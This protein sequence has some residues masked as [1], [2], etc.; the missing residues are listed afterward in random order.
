M[1]ACC[2]L[3]AT[4]GSYLRNPDGS[5]TPIEAP[6]DEA[7]PSE[8][9]ADAMPAVAPTPKPT[10]KRAVKAPTKEG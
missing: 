9:P 6:Q 8:A 7:A 10:V 1:K 2:P 3:P 5:L 4:G